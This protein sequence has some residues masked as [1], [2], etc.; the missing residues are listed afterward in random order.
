V[1][2]I[3]VSWRWNK[4][5]IESFLKMEWIEMREIVYMGEEALL[6]LVQGLR[7]CIQWEAER[8][9]MDVDEFMW[10]AV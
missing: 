10:E 2:I 7:G 8:I 5:E 1:Q 6:V 3:N 4:W 9:R